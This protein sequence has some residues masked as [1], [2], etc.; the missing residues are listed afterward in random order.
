M[1]KRVELTRNIFSFFFFFTDD[2]YTPLISKLENNTNDKLKL[3]DV[4]VHRQLRECFMV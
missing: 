3:S 1:G 4:A 2:I